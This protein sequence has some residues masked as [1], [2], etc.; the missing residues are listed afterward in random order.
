[1]ASP[2]PFILPKIIA[3]VGPA[4]AGDD[5][6]ASMIVEGVRVFRINFSHG[7][8]DDF[9]RM[10]DAVRRASQAT[11]IEV[12]VFG[13]LSGPKIRVG[14]VEGEG[15]MVEPGDTI[16]LQREPSEPGGDPLTFDV[17]EP[18][19]IDDVQPGERLL[20]NDGA[21]RAL[22]LE[23]HPD[24]L[25]ARITVG[26]LIT[27][28]KGVNLP[29][30]TLNVPAITDHDWRCVDWALE[31]DIDF[32]ALSF[33]RCAADVAQLKAYVKQQVDPQRGR[34]PITAKIEKPQALD[35]LDAILDEADA[36]MV[37]RGD[38]GVEMDQ[39]AV[40]I[41]Q[42]RIIAMA[43]DH[44]KPVMVAT[45]MLQSMIDA[46]DPTRAEVSDVANAI[47][48][49]ADCVMLSGETA[50]GRHPIKAVMMMS[51][52][53]LAMQD[54]VGR[55]SEQW[56]RPPKRLQESRY[57][58]A[59]L[60]HG[61]ATVV[62]DLAARAIVVWSQRGGGARY[63][64]QNRITVPIIAATSDRYAM[65]RMCPLFAVEPVLMERPADIAAFLAA[66]DRLLPQRG[67]A[68]PGDPIVVVTGDPLGDVGVT[69][70]LRIHYV[71]DICRVGHRDQG[72]GI[73]GQQSE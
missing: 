8:F 49:G 64:S 45:Q 24:A 43:H 25:L 42:K 4:C 54:H 71:G 53:A 38:L 22:V 56:G 72:S 10:L 40:P 47:F 19:I 33:V 63:L 26:G 16:R 28:R 2:R 48:D 20:I 55:S 31:H 41:I 30:S 32:L 50:V 34:L 29:D 35:D 36:V 5:T 59:A 3:T 73:R 37:A 51:R 27:S 15:V 62:R 21:I 58:T 1:M 44:G 46:S 65:R 18:S 69:N 67:W 17:T 57:R 12:A 11:G 7:S 39:V 68:D 6:L 23:S 9:E 52:I 13:D 60:A 70:T 61:V 66:I 14:R